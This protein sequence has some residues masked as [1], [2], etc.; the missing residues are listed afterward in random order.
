MC[1]VFCWRSKWF[2][3]LYAQHNLIPHSWWDVT[4]QLPL[5]K[6]IQHIWFKMSNLT[7]EI[8]LQVL[9]FILFPFVGF[10]KIL[11]LLILSWR[12]SAVFICTITTDKV[13]VESLLLFAGTNIGFCSPPDFLHSVLVF[14]CCFLEVFFF[15]YRLSYKTVGSF[16]F[17]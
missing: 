9:F 10:F 13:T 15:S 16:F 17:A 4:C 7:S 5:E 8:T 1:I 12:I 6:T 11:S 3:F 2:H 14:F